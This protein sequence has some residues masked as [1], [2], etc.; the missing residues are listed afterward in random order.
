MAATDAATACGYVLAS[1]LRSC[2]VDLTFTPVLDLDWGES[3]VIGDRALRDA[4]VK[5]VRSQE[6]DAWPVAG[7]YGQLQSGISSHRYV[8]ADS[9]RYSADKRSPEAILQDDAKP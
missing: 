1:E 6:R 5:V 7:G 2:G 4:K 9:A 3:G 8:K